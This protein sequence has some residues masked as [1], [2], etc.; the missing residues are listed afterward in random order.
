MKNAINFVHYVI[1]KFPVRIQNIRTSN[2]YVFRWHFHWHVEKDPGMSHMC[3]KPGI[4]NLKGKVERSHG[5]DQRE[6]YQ[7]PDYKGDVDLN[8]KLQEWEDFYNCC[9][10]HAAFNGKTPY[11]ILRE[12]LK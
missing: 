3:I 2:G 12:R 11:E 5:T 6:F 1:T 8:K 4:P 7:I 10:P 9:R